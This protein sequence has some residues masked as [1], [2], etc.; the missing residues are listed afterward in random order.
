MVGT[1]TEQLWIW[2]IWI[3]NAF[4]IRAPT[5]VLCREQQEVFLHRFRCW[6]YI[7]GMANMPF[8]CNGI[9]LIQGNLPR[10]IQVV[11]LFRNINNILGLLNKQAIL[12]RHG[13][14]TRGL[15]GL[16]DYT[17]IVL[18]CVRKYLPYKLGPPKSLGLQCWGLQCLFWN[19][20][21]CQ[22]LQCLNLQ[23][24]STLQ[25]YHCLFLL[26]LISQDDNR[27]LRLT[28]STAT[29]WGSKIGMP[30]TVIG[31]DWDQMICLIT[32]QGPFKNWIP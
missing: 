15:T 7:F 10:I 31:Q 28:I 14:Q 1:R 2:T 5:V 24:H 32:W 23:C 25:W 8:P 3:P 9:L 21:R 27:I 22:N 13:C 12:S 26:Q 30:D 20:L 19:N 4:R 29:R 16:S 17:I 11:F 6:K 18:N